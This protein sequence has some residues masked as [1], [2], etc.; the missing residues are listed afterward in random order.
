MPVLK[1]LPKAYIYEPWKA[2]ADVQKKA[3]VIVGKDYPQ[4]C[5]VVALIEKLATRSERETLKKNKEK[6]DARC[7]RETLNASHF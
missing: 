6:R 4:V 7:E 3:G 1:N 2:P 5:G